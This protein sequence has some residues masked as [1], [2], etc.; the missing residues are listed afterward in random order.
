[1][2]VFASRRREEASAARRSRSSNRTR[3]SSVGMARSP[4][5]T[6]LTVSKR[7]RHEAHSWRWRSASRRAAS[8]SWSSRKSISSVSSRCR[9]ILA[10]FPSRTARTASPEHV[11]QT[12]ASESSP[13]RRKTL[14]EISKAPACSCRRLF[15]ACMH[16][17]CSA[18]E[19]STRSIPIGSLPDPELYP[20]TASLQRSS[21]LNR[22]TEVSLSITRPSTPTISAQSKSCSTVTA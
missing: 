8:S 14:I 20:Q 7:E 21:F 13:G 19:R 6:L 9:R 22:S 3:N 2:K 11:S 16:E 1:M 15:I 17:V 12:P 18:S 10:R 5:I 4:A